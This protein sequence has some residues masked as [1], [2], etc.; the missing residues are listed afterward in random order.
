MSWGIHAAVGFNGSGKTL[1]VVEKYVLPA[2]KSGRAV[3]GNV[4]IG[5][6]NSVDWHPLARPLESWREVPA[7][8]DCVLVLDEITAVLPSRQSSSLPPEFQRILNQLRKRDVELCWTAPNWAR[9]DRILRE[10]T[11]DVIYCR[12]FGSDRFV[13]APGQKRVFPRAARYDENGTYDAGGEL[14][15]LHGKPGARVA[16]PRGARPR[17]LFRWV[18]YRADDFEEF[19][20]NAAMKLHP[21]ERRFYWRSSHEAHELYDTLQAVSLLDHLD[22]VGACVICGG[23]RE[24]PRCRCGPQGRAGGAAAEGGGVARL[25]GGL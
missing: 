11:T 2:L 4:R 6:S 18:T 22:D 10:V 3:V 24:R 8:R 23:K 16:Y 21:K 1:A 20:V 17:R 19:S 7:L 12:S 5:P 14:N 25:G 13:R 9:A 15:V